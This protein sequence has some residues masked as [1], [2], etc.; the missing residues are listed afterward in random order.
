MTL[1]SPTGICTQKIKA[2]EDNRFDVVFSMAVFMHLH[3][4]TPAEFWNHIARVARRYIVTIENEHC[5]G[6]RFWSRNY[7]D[8]FEATGAA[9]QVFATT[10]PQAIP[11]L[12]NYTVRVFRVC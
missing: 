6:D 3:P 1:T 12:E 2:L 5:Y 11:A 4:T 7:Q 9:K 8:L 10:H